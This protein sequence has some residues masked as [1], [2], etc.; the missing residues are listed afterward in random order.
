MKKNI[1]VTGGA[2]FIGSSLV[3]DLLKA[4]YNILCFDNF[5]TNYSNQIKLKNISEALK[6][7]NFLHIEGDITNKKDLKECFN[8]FLP[9]IVVHMAA[10]TGVRASLFEPLEYY[11]VNVEGTLNLLETMKDFNVKK[12]VFASSSSVYGNSKKLPFCETDPVDFPISPYAATKKACE[13]LCY[14]YHHL[15]GFD[16]FCL[17]FFTVYG[18]RQRPDLAIHKFSERIVNQQPI[19]I[20]GNGSTARDYTYIDD[21]LDGIKAAI[22]KL[23]GFEI[24]NLGESN[25]V[26]LRRLISIIEKCLDKKANI[27]QL[28]LQPG[29]V[30]S[31]Y[32]DITKARDLLDY[33]PKWDIEEG[34]KAF[35]EWKKA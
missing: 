35:I 12:M 29:D 31:T 5:D 19:D 2:G 11:R 1:L 17:R 20:Y 8:R 27:H 28:P 15:Y 6:H 18:P 21:I 9:E 3:D 7:P 4:G 30:T 16:V 32:A 14:T 22:E 26:T 23:K 34:I 10:K 33:R 25:V 13:L 24:I